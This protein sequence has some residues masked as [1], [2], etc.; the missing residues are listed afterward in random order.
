MARQIGRFRAWA[1][2]AAFAAPWAL[3][4]GLP[5]EHAVRAGATIG[6]LALAFDLY[7]RS[8]A[9]RN[10]ELAFT[11]LTS[12]QRSLILRETYRN[13]GRMAAE[14]VHF[15]ELD[16]NNIERYV[17]YTGR[18]H[19]DNAIERSRG[20]G[21]L[22]L[23]G[24]FGNF[25]L[26]S[27]AHSIYGNRIAIV[28][29]PNR[30]PMLDYAVAARRRRFGNLT[31]PRK[32]AAREVMRLLRENW[33]VAI[34]LDLDT[35]HGAFVDFFGTPA[36]TNPALARIAMASEAPVLPAFMVRQ[37]ETSRHQITILPVIEVHPSGNRD[38]SVREHTQVFTA[39]IE[40]MIRRYPDHWNWIHRRWKTRPQHE[41]R[42]Y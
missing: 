26:L 1:E 6:A 18:E 25:E 11:N 17:A 15:P 32:G 3:L 10:L 24:H 7:N 4:R 39:V 41:A 8:I 16:R 38:D 33:M 27:V 9:R 36:A 30:N 19:W 40:S 14:W 29:R 31:V 34:P 23:T 22:V 13:F 35:R 2:C 5:L 42:F 12:K 28:Q 37:G 20:R 21:I